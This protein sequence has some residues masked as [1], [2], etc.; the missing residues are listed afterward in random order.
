M[1]EVEAQLREYRRELARMGGIARGQRHGWFAQRP[2]EKA[3]ALEMLKAG[4]PFR[5]IAEVVGCP[6][7]Q[8]V[9]RLAMAAMRDSAS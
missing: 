4:L 1:S 7:W 2:E 3:A 6:H 9:Q 5:K 8:Y